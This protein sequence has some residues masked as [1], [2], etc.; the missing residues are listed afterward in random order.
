M[1][2]VRYMKDYVTE[3]IAKSN[4]DRRFDCTRN[5]SPNREMSQFLTAQL[6]G[7]VVVFS[8]V[9]QGTNDHWVPHKSKT[10]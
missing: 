7:A 6:N 3:V 2:D 10:G 1:S 4:L 8:K 9:V 5:D